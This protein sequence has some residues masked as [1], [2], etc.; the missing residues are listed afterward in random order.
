MAAATRT[1]PEIWIA[2]SVLVAFAATAAADA[3]VSGETVQAVAAPAAQAAATQPNGSESARHAASAIPPAPSDVAA[4]PRPQ[5]P[6]GQVWQCVFEGQRIFSDSPCGANASIRHLS[7]LNIMDPA[8]VIPAQGYGYGY[9]PPAP[10]APEAEST[11]AAADSDYDSGYWGPE[12]PWVYGRAH[13][14]YYLRH[15]AH[16]RPHPHPHPQ[17]HPQPRRN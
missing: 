12:V 10:Y 11:P 3:P 17:P 1:H 8:P 9:S 14:N 4:T 7:D 13:R 15:D 2:A 16:V 5:L 6:P